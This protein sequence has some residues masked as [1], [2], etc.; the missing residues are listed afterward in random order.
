MSYSFGALLKL[1]FRIDF[2]NDLIKVNDILG[3]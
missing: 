2:V 3:F 1:I